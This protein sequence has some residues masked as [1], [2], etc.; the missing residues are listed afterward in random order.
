MS[1]RD[2]FQR[3]AVEN[4][5]RQQ[6]AAAGLAR[7]S[8]DLG[9]WFHYGIAELRGETAKNGWKHEQ[10]LILPSGR[11]R[12]HDNARYVNGRDFREYKAALQVGGD[13]V[14]EQISKEREALQTDPKTRGAWIVR[15]GSLDAEARRELEKLE[16]DFTGRFRVEEVTRQQIAQAVM[17]G[18]ALE[19]E[20]GQ[21][22]LFD[23]AKLREKQLIKEQREKAQD[24][25]RTQKAAQR[26][27]EER[28][29]E[30]EAERQREEFQRRQREV[31]QRERAAVQ[32]LAEFSR[33]IREASARGEKLGMTSRAIA[34]IRALSFPDQ[35]DP[36][37]SQHHEHPHPGSTRAGRARDARGQERGVDR[38][39]R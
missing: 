1:S 8:N 10:S 20:R 16:R 33:E 14:M 5:R 34:D 35:L 12:I 18:K 23:S 28:A 7:R 19:R 32:R 22:E 24:K 29:R 11:E 25:L 26:A 13:F 9:R 15:E 31:H 17:M 37:R 27:M 6:R 30:R 4:A 3:R 2:E 38:G 36:A 39:P 21:L